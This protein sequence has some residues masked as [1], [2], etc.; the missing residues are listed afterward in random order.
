MIG[1]ALV[2]SI[3]LS[4]VLSFLGLAGC[5]GGGTV[6]QADT[7]R[8]SGPGIPRQDPISQPAPVVKAPAPQ[9]APAPL[10]APTPAPA[11]KIGSNVAFFPTGERATS[12][13][14]IEKTVP[15]EVVVGQ[16]FEY[17]IT[18]TNLSSTLCLDD[19]SVSDTLPEGFTVKST[20]PEATIANGV[21]NWKIKRLNP[22]EAKSFK[23]VGVASK[24]GTFQYCATAEATPRLCTDLMAVAPA[25]KLAKTQT[26]QVIICDPIT[27][28]YVVTNSGS[29]AARGVRVKDTLPAGL[30]TQSGASSVDLDAGTLAPGQSKEFTVTAQAKK[31]GEFASK[32]TAT[33]ET[34]LT[35]EASAGTVVKQPI[36]AIAKTA[37][38]ADQF[39]GRPFSFDVTVTN[40]GDAVAKDVVINDSLPASVKIIDAAGGKIA[41]TTIQ[42]AVGD[43]EPKA[44]KKFTIN[45]SGSE[46][47]TVRNTA[48]VSGKCAETVSAAAQINIKGIPAILLEVIDLDDPIE[49]GKEDTYEIVVTNQGSA[50]GTNIKIACVIEEGVSYVSSSGPTVGT[51]ANQNVT[52]APLATLAPKA[53]AT[54]KVVVRSTKEGDTRFKVVLTSDQIDRPV[55][56]TEST[57]F[58]K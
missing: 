53:K 26:P 39:V 23:V 14:M 19:V 44:S 2:S 37:S 16:P 52:F 48:T 38:R 6:G 36:L 42:W 28:K 33:S 29:G 54:W 58:Y 5:S 8:D 51:H 34:G 40:N 47:G 11:P 45:V 17:T 22:K 31:T 56:E 1:R 15:A 20:A 21:A 43:L 57:R 50:V 7:T 10:P 4:L 55:E 32:A 27:I 24:E 18:A 13:L 9:P 41:G 25:L 12:Y 46:I 3:C 49:V 35:A 30:V